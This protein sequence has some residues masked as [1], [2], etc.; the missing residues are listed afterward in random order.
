MSPQEAISEC[1]KARDTEAARW[2]IPLLAYLNDPPGSSRAVCWLCCCV[3]DLLAH[4]GKASAEFDEALLLAR[5]YA[6]DGGDPSEIE[7]AAWHLWPCPT[8]EYH[9]RKAVAQLLFVLSRGDRSTSR[10]SVGSCAV[11]IC[12]LEDLESRPGE[13]F[14]W[15]VAYFRRY[16]DG[17]LS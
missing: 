13:T 17:P 14:D 5:R 9:A 8:P 15:V 6:V 1:R 10:Y 11:P 12:L 16:T 2:P 7:R 4:F 3:G